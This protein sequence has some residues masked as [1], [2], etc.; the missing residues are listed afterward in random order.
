TYIANNG[1]LSESVYG[2]NDGVKYTY[3]YSGN[4][5]AIKH[6]D[7]ANGY[8]TATYGN[9]VYTWQYSSNGTPRMHQDGINQIRYDYSY[10][11]IGRLIRTDM[12]N[13]VTS[14]R[15]G[16][17]EYGYNTRGHLTSV[18]N[19]IGGRAYSQYYSYSD[20]GVTGA[21]EN[22]ADGLPTRYTALGVNTDYSYD[23][24]N[25]LT[26]RSVGVDDSI[27][28]LYYYKDADYREGYTTTQ[29]SSE[30]ID[31][32]IYAYTY[33]EMGNIST[34]KKNGVLYRSYEYDGLGQLTKENQHDSNKTIDYVYNHLGNISYKTERTTNTNTSAQ[35]VRTINYEYGKDGKTGWNYLLTG[36][37][38]DG[39]GVDENE[40][41]S[42]DDIGNP[43]VYRGAEMAWK[44][45]QLTGYA[46]NGTMST[47]SYDADGLRATKTVGGVK[48]IYQ[49]V[50]DKLYYEKRGDS[51]EFYY[52]YDSYG[53]LSSIYYT[54]STDDYTSSANYYVTTNI[55][56]DVTALYNSTGALVARYE[57]DAWG[58]VLSVTDANGNAI[59]QWYHIANANPI[60]Y[61]GYYYDSDL[62]LYYL[63]SRYYDS[64]TGRF[65]N[66]DSQL[67][68]DILGSNSFCYCSNNPISRTD[69]KGKA[70]W[71]V[72]GATIG[73]FVG[74][75]GKIYSNKCNGIEWYTGVIGTALG[76]A[77]GGAL[78]AAGFPVSAA[79]VG[80]AVESLVN[81]VITYTKYAQLSGSNQKE[82]I[83]ENIGESALSIV[84]ETIKNGSEAYIAD[85]LFDTIMPEIT[86]T[87]GPFDSVNWIS[88]PSFV[89]AS[90]GVSAVFFIMLCEL[91]VENSSRASGQNS[92]ISL[93]TCDFVEVTA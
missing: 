47:F 42:Y 83:L 74:A 66:S 79:Y 61:R 25:R 35:I 2:N 21:K 82:V 19:E 90:N 29:V 33:D 60:R 78:S 1:G 77:I 13:S 23:S 5:I 12:S 80:A 68:D 43:I 39:N 20:T 93:F 4:V 15:V 70:Y 38:T 69:P 17:T 65:L 31:G 30:N 54:F 22:A 41:I 48:T 26:M 64:E 92:T 34:I 52:F 7:N 24:L 36:Y 62:G 87:P 44:G 58:N 63:Q 49:Y 72:I 86:F 3:D 9:S 10:D 81:E 73:G 16:S 18:S 45:R 76:G 8:N 57:Y 56:G 88:L 51:Q 59:T 89:N 14:A 85:T 37:D 28:T 40:K 75:F 32:T 91:I 50:G 67:N 46:K 55:Q 27:Y 84:L 53:K 11:S 6:K 71:I